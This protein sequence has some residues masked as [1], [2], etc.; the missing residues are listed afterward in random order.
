M[1]YEYKKENVED[2]VLALGE[3]DVVQMSAKDFLSLVGKVGKTKGRKPIALD[4]EKFKEVVAKWQSGAITARFAMNELGL[5]PNTFY[6][7]VKEYTEMI[8]IKEIKKH[9]KEDAKEIEN[10]ID[11][12]KM[13]KEIRWEKLEAEAERDKEICALEMEV[14]AEAE[15]FKNK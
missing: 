6:R 7:R 1:I 4:E 11:V 13:E 8:D 12:L 10:T 5:K 15:E 14:A 2:L 9:I 3:D